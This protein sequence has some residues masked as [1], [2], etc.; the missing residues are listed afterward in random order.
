[1]ADNEYFSHESPTTGDVAHRLRAA[2]IPYRN[3]GEN[4]A[5]D[6]SVDNAHRAFMNS[7]AHRANVLNPDFTNLGIGV[8]QVGERVMVTEAFTRTRTR[9]QPGDAQTP[10]IAAPAS[11]AP[12]ATEDRRPRDEAVPPT[13]PASPAPEQEEP[14]TLVSP[15]DL[16][17]RMVGAIEE[18]LPS[19]APSQSG[20]AAR[21]TRPANPAPG[22]WIVSEDGT[23][24]RV[25][26]DADDLLRLMS[27]L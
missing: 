24:H 11:S 14:S 20:P 23:W 1:M 2:S 21:D 27:V 8:V 12:T 17:G 13:P 10:A 15:F 9:T 5:L 25:D 7:P 4:I 22:I 3:A 16:L 6:A 19:S 18:Q 26:L